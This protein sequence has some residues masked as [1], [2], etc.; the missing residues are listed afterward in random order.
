MTR[1][2]RNTVV[3]FGIAIAGMTAIACAP[4]DYEENVRTSE[5]ALTPTP[6]GANKVAGIDVSEYQGTVDW[7]SHKAK[8]REFAIT[9]IGDGTYEDPTFDR[10]WKGIKAAGMI[11]GAYQFF[12]PGKDPV[13]QADIVI[14]RVGKLA[15]GDLPCTIDVEAT[16]GQ[17]KEVIADKVKTWLERVEAGTGR[18]P[19]IYTGP[20][21][22]QDNV[23]SMAFVDNPLWI[24]HYGAAQPSLPAPWKAFAIWQYGDSDGQLDV[25][26]FNGSKTELEAFAQ[27]GGGTT[28]P[29]STGDASV[30]E[31]PCA[32]G[33]TGVGCAKEAGTI[34]VGFKADLQAT[35][36]DFEPGCAATGSRNGKTSLAPFVGLAAFIG[37]LFVRRKNKSS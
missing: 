36:D 26:W 21:F 15:P 28:T 22:W 3:A 23:G 25:D 18:K 7:P 30:I 10:N 12:R 5:E 20:Y 33:G 6:L 16:D 4:D 37:M 32:D 24:A 1:I 19:I 8:G 35:D 2:L 17:S 9:R 29:S 31:D 13:A 11:R 14:R 27:V 34:S